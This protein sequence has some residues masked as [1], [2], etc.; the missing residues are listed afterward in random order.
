MQ[1][2]FYNNSSASWLTRILSIP[3]GPREVRSVLEIDEAAI[4]FAFRA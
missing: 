1:Y 3:F 4:I 2:A